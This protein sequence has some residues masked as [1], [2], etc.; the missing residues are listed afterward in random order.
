[1]MRYGMALLA[2]S[3]AGQNRLVFP[4]D[5]CKKVSGFLTEKIEIPEDNLENFKK[6][7]SNK[8]GSPRYTPLRRALEKGKS[9]KVE[10]Q[11]LLLSNPKLLSSPG[12]LTQNYFEDALSLAHI[13]KLVRKDHNLLLTR[14]R[15]SLSAEWRL[16]DPFQLNDIDS[17]YLGLWLL[18]IDRDWIWAF[19]SQIPS[20]PKFEITTN[21]R[22]DLL[23]KSWTHILSA[24]GIRSRRPQNAE[25]RTRLIKLREITKRNTDEKLNFGQPW[26]WFLFPR[27]EL[28]VDAGVFKKKERHG[29]SGYKLTSTGHKMRSICVSHENGEKLLLNY[30][31][32]HTSTDRLVASNIEWEDFESKLEK[33]ASVIRTPVGY[34]P[35]FETAVAVCADQFLAPEQSD[36]PLWE[37]EN[38]KELLWKESKSVSS[39]IRLAID[40]Q[41]QIYAFKIK[42]N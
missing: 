7:L 21:N 32:C 40:R 22:V 38:V 26:S 1:M 18:D 6:Y 24:R 13:L 10:K 39:R 11:D 36:A 19:L 8:P 28:L 2:S 12:A 15:L 3:F 4:E 33:I 37:I 41:G 31:S 5:I 16:E 20:D 23:Q 25:I 42:Q 34:F 30:F 17:L 27:L 35:I 14:G 9:I 29:L